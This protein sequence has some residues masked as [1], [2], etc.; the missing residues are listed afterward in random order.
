MKNIFLD[1][2]TFAGYKKPS[3]DE[4]KA[5]VNYKDP[6]KIR[7]YKEECLDE[8]WRKQALDSMKG[9]IVAIGVA[10]D[11]EEP[12]TF[13]D[14]NNEEMVISNFMI[15]LNDI[16]DNSKD[17]YTCNWIAHN[18]LGFDFPW[19]Y[20]RIKKYGFYNLMPAPKSPQYID[21]MKLAA[22]TNY[23]EMYSLDELCEFFD[24][25][26]KNG[27]GSEVHDMILNKKISEL[28]YYLKNDIILLRN[29]YKKLS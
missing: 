20:H 2:E 23:K 3:L 15:H 7:A 13:C 28:L 9:K 22:F 12:V 16:I 4:I 29:L 24:I 25:G 17:F 19:L 26:C 11:D 27:H 5:P 10:I 14:L 8:I 1:I 6:E 21:T 18:G